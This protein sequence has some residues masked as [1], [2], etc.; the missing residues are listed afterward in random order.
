[1]TVKIRAKTVMKLSTGQYNLDYTYPANASMESIA[2]DVLHALVQ[3]MGVVAT[4]EFINTFLKNYGPDYPGIYSTKPI[5][6]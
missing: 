3:N 5:K 6:E 2:K 4:N 1:M